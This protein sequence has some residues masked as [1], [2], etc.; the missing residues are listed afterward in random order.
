MTGNS[1]EGG[2]SWS[3][4]ALVVRSGHLGHTQVCERQLEVA[5]VEHLCSYFLAARGSDPVQLVS[6][7]LHRFDAVE[8]RRGHA[9]TG[10]SVDQQACTAEALELLECGQDSHLVEVDASVDLVRADLDPGGSDTGALTRAVVAVQDSDLPFL[11]LL[12][13]TEKLRGR[14]RTGRIDCSL[15]RIASSDCQ[16]LVA[17]Q[18]PDDR[19]T[20]RDKPVHPSMPSSA[21]ITVSRTCAIPASMDEGCAWMVLLRAYMICLLCM[22]QR[23]DG[24]AVDLIVLPQA[25]CGNGLQ[26]F[27]DLFHSIQQLNQGDPRG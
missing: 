23:L 2:G 26:G 17:M 11:D 4:S 13:A 25:K 8:G 10:C 21:G 24:A 20:N 22:G 14:S 18:W 9:T 19:S 27:P 6:V 1:H 7:P 16:A 15:A 12:R 5:L 3:C